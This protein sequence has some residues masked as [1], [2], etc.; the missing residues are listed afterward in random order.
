MLPDAALKL[1]T[2]AKNHPEVLLEVKVIALRALTFTFLADARTFRTEIT[3]SLRTRIQAENYVPSFAVH[4]RV[5]PVG[6]H[7][8]LAVGR[9]NT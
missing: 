1:L 6:R 5:L 3:T 9:S 4:S 7:I 8:C 2:I